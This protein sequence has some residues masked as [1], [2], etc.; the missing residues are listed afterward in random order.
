MSSMPAPNVE[1]RRYLRN[2]SIGRQDSHTEPA[3]RPA[4]LFADPKLFEPDITPHVLSQNAEDFL[5]LHRGQKTRSR[6]ETFY[7]Q[8]GFDA[9]WLTLV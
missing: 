9:K 6:L 2:P 3:P 4:A 8:R 5:G 7:T 1:S